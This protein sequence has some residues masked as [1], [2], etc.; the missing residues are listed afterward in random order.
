MVLYLIQ[1]QT[2]TLF[3]QNATQKI[4]NQAI[5]IAFKLLTNMFKIIFLIYF[6]FTGWHLGFFHYKFNVILLIFIFVFLIFHYFVIVTLTVYIPAWHWL[7]CELSGLLE[8]SLG[9]LKSSSVLISWNFSIGLWKIWVRK[10][11][12]NT[13]G[14]TNLFT[15][16]DV[17]MYE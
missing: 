7:S 13:N 2:N 1:C 6:W 12:V 8:Y 15:M 14:I 11:I 3:H 9:M 4:T 16:T 17:Y 10:Y 5:H